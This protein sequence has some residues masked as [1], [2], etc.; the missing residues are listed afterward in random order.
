MGLNLMNISNN[1]S[2]EY[3]EYA[4]KNVYSQLILPRSILNSLKYQKFISRKLVNTEIFHIYIS[5]NIFGE[6]KREKY[7]FNLTLL[8]KYC[9]PSC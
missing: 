5:L 6:N 7:L 9:G 3:S 8:M 1:R 4:L 2:I